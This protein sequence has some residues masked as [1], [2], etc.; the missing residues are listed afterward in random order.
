M[1]SSGG[2]EVDLQYLFE[3]ISIFEDIYS[4]GMSGYIKMRDS[5][6]LPETFP[7]IGE[8][9]VFIKFTSHKA[10]N[11]ETV[12][13]KTFKIHKID[14]WSLS[15][16]E[17]YASYIIHFVSEPFYNN[18][19]LRLNRSFG[20]EMKPTK[21]SDI[22]TNVCENMLGIKNIRVEKTRFDRNVICTNWTPFQLFNFLGESDI[23]S[24]KSEVT[25]KEST[26]LFF[27]DRYGY[28]FVSFASLIED[29]FVGKSNIKHLFFDNDHQPSNSSKQYDVRQVLD[30]KIVETASQMKNTS[31]GMFN[32]RFFYHDI[33]NKTLTESSF[34]YDNEFDKMSNIDSRQSYP[35]KTHRKIEKKE[36][37]SF[38]P[39]EYSYKYDTKSNRPWRQISKS[40]LAMFENFII[41]AEVTGSSSHRLGNVVECSVPSSRKNPNGETMR[42]EQMSG[43]YLISKIRHVIDNRGYTQVLELR[44]GSQHKVA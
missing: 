30:F 26:F 32:N 28:N 25:D 13:Q 41:Q 1:K 11:R 24:L 40:R 3:Y 44:K 27:E 2:K 18:L 21:S 37:T 29:K 43:K 12:F 10:M 4:N 14:D 31:S 8:E 15:T 16:N 19:T 36:S 6:N 42:Y 9:T 38:L 23:S 34:N 22:V 39:G 35:L 33:I 17:E 20:S 7:I 5:Y